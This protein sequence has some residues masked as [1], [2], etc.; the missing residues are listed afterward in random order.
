MTGIEY[1][2]YCLANDHINSFTF[3]VTITILIIYSVLYF[4]VD[5]N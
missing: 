4:I 5:D 3:Y 1:E 2:N